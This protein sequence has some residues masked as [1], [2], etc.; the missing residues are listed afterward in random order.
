MHRAK[1]ARNYLTTWFIPDCLI[2]G[3]DWMTVIAGSASGGQGLLRVGK[4][5]RALR[6]LRGLRLVRLVKVMRV[7]EEI[8]DRISSDWLQIGLS[9]LKLTI[10]LLVCNHLIAC[11]WWGLG[12][13]PPEGEVSWIEFHGFE[14]EALGYKYLSSLH[15]TLT[16][17]T[18]AGMEVYPHNSTERGFSV[19]V[20]LFALLFF[21]SFLSS[22]TAAMTRLRSLNQATNQQFSMLRRFL[23]DRQIPGELATRIKR[24]L[25]HRIKAQ[26]SRTQEK[27][28]GILVLLSKPLYEEL[29]EQTHKPFLCKHP[30]FDRYCIVAPHAMR[31]VCH[32]A[33]RTISLSEG[34]HLFTA[35]DKCEQMVFVVDGQLLYQWHDSDQALLDLPLRQRPAPQT[36][37]L[38]E[39]D[40]FGEACLWATWAYVGTMRAVAMSNLLAVDGEKFASVTL[41]HMSAIQKTSLYAQRFLNDLNDTPSKQQNDLPK[42]REEIEQMCL[43]VFNTHT[44]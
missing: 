10:M 7:V 2:V 20:L 1:I 9:V 31:H 29:V 22:I 39:G 13:V 32:E 3:L 27:D 42:P 26:K 44:E 17:F 15:W 8:Q 14:H 21:S 36:Q 41:K 38:Q 43:E 37:Y 23:Q 40:W 6:V 12:S 33:V 25:E 16:Q 11:I 30:F 19:V 5:F 34:D 18:P 4:A 24:Y 28:V 35:G